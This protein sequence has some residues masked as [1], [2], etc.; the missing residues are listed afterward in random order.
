MYFSLRQ[1]FQPDHCVTSF[2]HWHAHTPTY[3]TEVP[4]KRICL[5]RHRLCQVIVTLS[6]W[7]VQS[8]LIFACDLRPSRANFIAN[9]SVLKN[10]LLINIPISQKYNTPIKLFGL[11]NRIDVISVN[12]DV[13]ESSD[14]DILRGLDR[15][16]MTSSPTSSDCGL[17]YSQHLFFL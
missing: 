8:S 11:Y 7:S 5:I 9:R 2:R 15:T 14:T 16:K 3:S 4:Q 13:L 6:K 10:I 1:A 12:Y 17:K